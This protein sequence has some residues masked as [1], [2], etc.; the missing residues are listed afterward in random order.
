MPRIPAT[1]LPGLLA[2]LAACGDGPGITGAEGEV[3][4]GTAAITFPDT[5]VGHPTERYLE[6]RNDGRTEHR[7]GADV[8]GPFELGATS[9]VLAGGARL[10]L[11]VRFVP[12]GAGAFEGNVRVTVRGEAPVDVPLAGVAREPPSCA[13]PT[14][15]HVAS[16]DPVAGACEV[17][18]RAPFESCSSG[19]QCVS[20]EL[21]V[22]GACVG[23]AI[24]CDDEDVCTDDGCDRGTGCVHVDLSDRC[25][26]PDA[27]CRVPACNPLVGC[28]SV[29]APDGTPCGPA[30]CRLASICILGACQEVEVPEGSPCPHGCG[31]GACERGSCELVGDGLLVERFRLGEADAPRPDALPVQDE[32]GRLYARRCDAS[33]CAISGLDLDGDERWRTEPRDEGRGSPLVLVGGTLAHGSET[34][35][36]GIDRET[37]AERWSV[38]LPSDAVPCVSCGVVAAAATSAEPRLAVFLLADGTLVALDAAD[39]AVAQVLAGPFAR[40]ALLADAGTKVIA[41]ELDDL[42]ATGR[43]SILDVGTGL[44][45]AAELGAGVRIL[46]VTGTRALL[47]D[48][49]ALDLETATVE[50]PPLVEAFALARSDGFVTYRLLEGAFDVEASIE[51]AGSARFPLPPASPAFDGLPSHVL[52]GS[53]GTLFALRTDA[54]AF[55]TRLVEVDREGTQL[56]DCPLPSIGV[57]EAATIAGGHLVVFGTPA[58]EPEVR[59]YELPLAEPS[60]VGW[61]GADGD[62]AGGGRPR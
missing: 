16:F 37:G 8:S 18:E 51:G 45:A 33:G 3:V 53:A 4:I 19:D 50:P 28:V 24:S 12:E 49:G 42:G 27:P 48:G 11:P 39:G 15:C 30:D 59:A 46:G 56:R 1:A 35:L 10:P 23:V 58:G 31:Q 17:R 44:S 9:F 36:A 52:L 13:A 14:P 5:W 20:E 22:E 55:E 2:V 40:A 38:E 60:P 32:A 61:V 25:P 6:L 47:S 7:V 26:P 62:L 41:A 34:G 57:P 54:R 21:C 43:V 29:E